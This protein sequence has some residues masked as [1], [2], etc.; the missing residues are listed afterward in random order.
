MA[1]YRVLLLLAALAAAGD[2]AVQPAENELALVLPASLSLAAPS[3]AWSLALLDP[4]PGSL[5]DGTTATL[6]YT[7]AAPSPD[8]WLGLYPAGANPLLTVPL[9]LASLNDTAYLRT[10]AGS[11]RLQLIALRE[12]VLTVRLFS[13]APV[14]G[15]AVAALN[16]TL[17]G[18]VLGPQRPR[19]SV[20]NASHLRVT[21]GSGR[22]PAQAQPQLSWGA[23]AGAAQLAA[24]VASA[25]LDAGALCGAPANASG[26][27]DL[28][29]THSAL[30]DL[31]LLPG[32]RPAAVYYRLRDAA[33]E[34]GGAVR[35][36][37]PRAPPAAPSDYPYTLLALD[38]LGRG[39]SDDAATFREY[40]R[41]ALNTSA[42]LGAHA[43][44]AEA[45]WI[46]GDLSYATGYLAVW[47]WWLFMVANW[48]A[49]V[50]TLFGTGNHES[51]A[52]HEAGRGPAPANHFSYFSTADSGGECGVVTTHLLPLPG[53]G[54]RSA[55]AQADAPWWALPLGPFYLVT[56]SSEHD[57]TRGSPQ[58]A[59]LERTLA[60]VNRSAHPF[61]L[62]G[63]HRPMY[64][65]S[66]YS[67]D[68]RGGGGAPDTA[69]TPVAAA[70]QAAVEPLTMRYKV[71]LALYGHNHA[72]Q[73]LSPAYR[74]ASVSRSA[75]AAR[76]DGSATALYAAPRA[77]LHYVIGTG[78]AGFT[79]N[80]AACSGL[81]PPGFSERVWYAWGALRVTAVNASTL[82]L[83]WVEAASGAVLDRA[84][85]VQDLEQAWA[86]E[87]GGGGGGGGA[88][89][90]R[91]AGAAGAAGAGLAALAAV[92]GALAAVR[93]W[94]PR[95]CSA[96][97][98]RKGQYAVLQPGGSEAA[99]GAAAAAAGGAEPGS[100]LHAVAMPAYG[101]I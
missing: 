67:A 8:D 3:A 86:D 72:V 97:G 70:L 62:L 82:E 4:A 21:W 88:Q 53:A 41:P 16:L 7:A 98:A 55:G 68:G 9:K 36:R 93:G 51:G 74:N 57:F 73:R 32:G 45:V 15:T 85:L 5:A 27:L 25:R 95:C 20:E 18:D 48:T 50:P 24:P 52:L 96:R 64:I 60:A 75:P 34:W 89:A 91:G 81:A 59:W 83:D 94:R 38:D 71:T 79:R 31:G 44:E 1:R 69:D 11:R 28:G 17:A 92:G 47:E 13:G 61:L 35:A 56:L 22:A 54:A 87:G 39:S 77:T 43:G 33:S 10:G 26:Y 100:A 14:G 19:L 23:D 101:S 2:A 40:G 29:W 49:H 99:A 65:D 76:A 30:L 58:L 63:C 6:A 37:V 90:A 46:T 66:T 42:W 84:T 80:C 78:G 12:P